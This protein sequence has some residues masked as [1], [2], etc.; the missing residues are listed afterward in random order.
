MV[1]NNLST[2]HNENRRH[3][4][5]EMKFAGTVN[6][7]PSLLPLY[8]GAS[9]IQRALQVLNFLLNITVIVNHFDFEYFYVIIFYSFHIS[10]RMESR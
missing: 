9:P 3:T 2:Y 8:R 1:S 10:T 5:H 4:D 6:I 7:H